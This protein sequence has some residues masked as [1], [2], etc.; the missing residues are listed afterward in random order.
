MAVIDVRGLTLI[1]S[2]MK[3]KELL[4]NNYLVEDAEIVVI[5]DLLSCKVVRKFAV[6]FGFNTDMQKETDYFKVKIFKGSAGE[7]MEKLKGDLPKEL[8]VVGR[9]D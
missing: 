1:E 9:H 3:T 4:M 5:G 2:L 6:N 7:C 8:M